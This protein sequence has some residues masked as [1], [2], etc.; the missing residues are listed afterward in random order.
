VLKSVKNT[1][2]MVKKEIRILG[3]DDSPFDKKRKSEV[4]VIGTIFRGGYFIDGVISTKVRMDGRNA[5]QKLIKMINNT[6]HKAQLQVIMLNGISLGGFNII[7]IKELNK[8]TKLPVVVVI[9][10]YPDFKKIH[11]ALIKIG[12]SDKIKLLNKAGQIYSLEKIFV[13]LAGISIVK[14]KEILKV[15]CTHSLIPEPIR[16]AH[17]IAGGIVDGESRGRA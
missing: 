1:G 5:T 16:V 2:R 7:D 8:A 6:K 12:F 3:I 4:L 11:K 9:R 15:S 13:Q 10:K 17:L 14:A